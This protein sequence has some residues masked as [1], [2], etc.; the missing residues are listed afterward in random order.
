MKQ[1]RL[2]TKGV[3]FALF[4]TL[5]SVINAFSQTL[6]ITTSV[7]T[8]ATEVRLTGPFWGWN[9]T[10][11]PAA[12]SNGDGTWTFTFNPAPTA[13]M[14]YL[15][16]VDG[17]Q[18]NLIQAMVNGGTCAPVTNYS[19]Y[20]NRRWLITD[21]L[22]IT[23]TYGQCGTCGGSTLTQMDL[24]VTFEGSTIEYGVI[25]FEGAQASTI[26]VDPTN[27]NNTVV[28]VIK[29]AAAQPWAGTTITAAAE[30]GLATPIPF[31]ASNQTMTLKVWSPD[32][33]ITVRMKV[34]EHGNNT[35]TVETDA[36]TTVAGQ[37]ETL[38]FNFANQGAGTAAINLA[39]T[40]DK[41]TVFFNYG[42][43]G[44]TA[45]EKTYYFDDLMMGTGG[46]T[47]L[48]QMT[49]P[50][51][52][53]GTTIDY[54]VIGFEGAQA[55]T[56]EVDPTNANNT[57]VKVIKSATAQPW[58]GTTI[59][60]AAELG[61]AS[62]IPFT[63]SNQKMTLKVWSPDAGITVRL[64]VEEHGN[65][66]HTVETDAVTTVA[67][68]WETL[69]F[70]FANQGAGT[71]AINLAYTY[72]KPTVFFNY[73][74]NGATAGEKTYYFD[75]LKMYALPAS[76][77]QITVDVCSIAATEVRMT[78][79]FW[80]W[81]PTA[82]PFAV[83]NN[84]GTWTFTLDPIP[85][86]DM[87]YLIIVNG[88]QES[89]I[90][91]MQNGGNCAPVT[92]FFGYANRKWVV[93]SGNVFISYDR[94][95]PCS[96]PNIVITTEV[97]STATSVRLTGPNWQWNPNFGPAA[98]SNGDGTYTFT[99]SPAP[100]DTLEY[101]LV[102]DGVI[103]NLIQE[104][105]NGA[106]CAPLTDYSTYANRRWIIGQGAVSNTY[107]RCSPCSIGIGELTDSDLV[108]FPNPADSKVT[109]SS[110]HK[111]EKIEIYSMLGALIA[112]KKVE[113]NETE[114]NLENFT[115]G[116]YTFNVYANDAVKVVRIIKN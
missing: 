3:F 60:A 69:T 65:N 7:C 116:V 88:V 93:G 43:N 90:S 26:E 6:T 50:V 40:Y 70:D 47:G 21:P 34:E 64:K 58:A 74:V 67:G 73:G 30:L 82:G 10:G 107:G 86:T 5:F 92:D 55:S 81:D 49:L 42:V 108:I 18:E 38:T 56:I 89:L 13:D 63:A 76:G 101:L 99:I 105:V 110:E 104:M 12:V 85:T 16:I 96:Y 62:P 52:F 78:G 35:H 46:G 1:N 72:D 106:G 11:G 83:N 23:N 2:F 75:D 115:P 17:V 102:K 114:I 57:V 29:S 44:A 68:Q 80:S 100:N 84:D 24:P 111:I 8:S 4:L 77:L 51:N 32:A 54:G 33:G 97:C 27:A 66:T 91:D 112:T 48:A 41:P 98:V 22:T 9:P 14:E 19:S 36:V 31:T 45:G 95:V 15:L 37:W 113:M 28:K 20:A 61:L 79:P 25:G 94:C 39:Y 53:E 59:T 71:A 87:E 109:V 103:E